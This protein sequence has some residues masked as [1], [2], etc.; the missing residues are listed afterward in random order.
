MLDLVEESSDSICSICSRCCCRV[1]TCLEKIVSSMITSLIVSY[2]ICFYLESI[3]PDQNIVLM[4][5]MFEKKNTNQDN[6]FYA[7][8]DDITLQKI[9]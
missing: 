4:R 7:A 9:K 5:H 8:D 3:D 1:P 2:F 6:S